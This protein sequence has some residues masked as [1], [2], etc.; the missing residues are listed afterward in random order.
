MMMYGATG[1]VAAGG[2][3]GMNGTSPHGNRY[4]LRHAALC[5]GLMVLLCIASGCDKAGKRAGAKNEI[6]VATYNIRYCA[7]GRGSVLNAI[8]SLGADVI[9]LQ[10]DPVRGGESA[11]S[12]FA[13]ALG[14]HHASSAPYA[15]ENATPWALSILS[16]HPII[17]RDELR[18]KSGRR[19]LRVRIS[20]GGAGCELVTAH[21]SP[22][23]WDATNPVAA[24]RARSLRRREELRELRAWLGTPSTPRILLGDFNSLPVMGEL[25]VLA[26][27]G[28]RSVWDALDM[29][30]QGTF[31]LSASVH[32][33]VKKYLPIDEEIMLDYIFVSGGITVLQAGVVRSDASD[34]YPLTARVR[35]P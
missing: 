11:G 25:A 17:S 19:A 28:Y 3:F 21:L 2:A 27:D 12:A 26:D 6:T 20:V 10:E 14:M 9:A 8:R 18:V 33:F 16:A 23:V 1:H 4:A 35:L 24:N 13:R 29:P 30:G 31:R 32:S 5:A 34:H 7:A 15:V 22:F